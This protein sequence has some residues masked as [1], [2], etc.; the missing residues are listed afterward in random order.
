MWWTIWNPIVT[1]LSY[2]LSLI[3]TTA[4]ELPGLAFQEFPAASGPCCR[5][6]AGSGLVIPVRRIGRFMWSLQ[7]TNWRRR[8]RRRSSFSGMMWRSVTITTKMWVMIMIA[9]PIM[10]MRWCTSVMMMRWKRQ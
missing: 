2:L 8:R 9:M 5:W 3:Q 1:C 4:V 10:V 7:N 6:K